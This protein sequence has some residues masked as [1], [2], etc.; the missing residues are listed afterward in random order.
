MGRKVLAMARFAVSIALLIGCIVLPATAGAQALTFA[1]DDYAT[2]A[3]ARA[4]VAADFNR[5]G[6][7]DVA[8]ASLT[9]NNVTILLSRGGTSLVRAFDIPSASAR[10]I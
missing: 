9:T 7:L 2:D 4:I 1:K 6:W 8:E 5:D 3:G 10:L